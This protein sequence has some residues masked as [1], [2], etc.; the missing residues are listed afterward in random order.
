[1]SDPFKSQG[2]A[3]SMP[4]PTQPLDPHPLP[5]RR[6]LILASI[7]FALAA[8]ALSFVG[9][10]L[11]GA[12]VLAVAQGLAAFYLSVAMPPAGPIINP[13]PPPPPGRPPALELI[14]TAIA[15]FAGALIAYGLQ[16]RAGFVGLSLLGAAL[17]GA[18]AVRSGARGASA[19]GALA[20]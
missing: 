8:A 15:L 11:A 3:R 9:Q 4:V 20:G 7:A 2:D 16:S 17:E 13:P 1:M 18:Y 10:W 19:P 6:G 14:V 5:P 12:I